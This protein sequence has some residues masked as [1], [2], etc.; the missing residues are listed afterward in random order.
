MRSI[1]T[2]L[3]AALHRLGCRHCAD[4]IEDA[5]AE[6]RLSHGRVGALRR[7]LAEE[8]RKTL[9]LSARLGVMERAR[10]QDGGGW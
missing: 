10:Q 6:L 9:F 4:M 7:E 8:R 5:H 1:V 2:F 3:R